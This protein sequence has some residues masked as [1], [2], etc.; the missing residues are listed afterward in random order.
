MFYLLKLYK[1]I[2]YYKIKYFKYITS[3]YFVIR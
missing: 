3:I 1:S 2:F